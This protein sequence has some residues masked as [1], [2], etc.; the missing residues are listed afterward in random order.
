[1]T[2]ALP[3]EAGAY[4]ATLTLTDL[5]FGDVVARA[6]SVAVFVPGPRRATLR[7]RVRDEAIE[8][9]KVVTVS[10]LVAN[11][12][13]KSWA[14]HVRSAGASDGPIPVR[15]TRVVARWIPLDAPDAPRPTPRHRRRWTC[16]R[17]RW[18]RARPRR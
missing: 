4:R 3:T 13:R 2:A 14:E 18:P 15:A 12:G 1:M 8:A 10:V 11:S 7:L 17:S 9:G 6:E 16:R 5:R